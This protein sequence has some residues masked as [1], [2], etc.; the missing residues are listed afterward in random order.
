M[1]EQRKINDLEL[2]VRTIDDMLPD[3]PTKSLQKWQGIMRTTLL[4]I[5][6]EL[7]NTYQHTCKICFFQEWGYRDELPSQWYKKGDAE[8]CFQHEYAASEKLLKDA[9][10]EVDAFF[11]PEIPAPTLEGLK[12]TMSHLPPAKTEVDHTLDELMAMI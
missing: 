9:G 2:A 4:K 3:M 1:I 11:P 6:K 10:Y 7:T 8:V 12:V 5:E